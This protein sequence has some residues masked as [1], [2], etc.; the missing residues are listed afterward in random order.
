MRKVS[1]SQF[2]ISRSGRR[3]RREHN[4]KQLIKLL[5]KQP[6]VGQDVTSVVRQLSDAS[7]GRRLAPGWGS[8]PRYTS[9]QVPT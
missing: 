7:V 6:R 5:R 1:T 2:K 3:N 8:V 4:N 9:E